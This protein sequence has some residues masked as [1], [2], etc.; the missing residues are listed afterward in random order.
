MS[1]HRI[2]FTL[3]E[4]LIVV[5]IIAI[6]AAIA[7]PNFLEAQ[8][9]AKVSRVIADMRTEGMAITSYEVDNLQI[10]ITRRLNPYKDEGEWFVDALDRTDGNRHMGHLLTTPIEYLGEIPWDYFNNNLYIPVA[11]CFFDWRGDLVAS[12]FSGAPHGYRPHSQVGRPAINPITEIFSGFWQLESAG[13]DRDWHC[14]LKN[15][16]YFYDPT[17]GTLSPGQIVYH[18][19]GRIVPGAKKKY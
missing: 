8:T 12:I 14:N 5:A 18:H 9:R 19:D 6:L 4:L 2:G 13:P 11:N 16:E 1:M 3:I 10:P 15:L 7:V 17:N